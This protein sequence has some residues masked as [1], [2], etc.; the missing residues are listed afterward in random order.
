MDG[1]FVPIVLFC[2]IGI[3]IHGGYRLFDI[4]EDRQGPGS[5]QDMTLPQPALG[6]LPGTPS[7]EGWVAASLNG[8]GLARK[9]AYSNLVRR[10]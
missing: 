9:A 7:D 6:S 3:S 8:S 2:V 5:S 1:I 10:H 4:V